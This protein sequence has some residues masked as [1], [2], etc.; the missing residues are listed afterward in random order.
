VAQPTAELGEPRPTMTWVPVEGPDG[1]VR[2]EARWVV[3]EPL[4]P[5]HDTAA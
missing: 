3:D 4:V 5:A 1:R 2:M